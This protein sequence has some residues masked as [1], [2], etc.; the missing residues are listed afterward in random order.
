MEARNGRITTLDMK[1]DLLALEVAVKSFKG[2]TVVDADR[3]I[4][5]I[6]TG[7]KSLVYGNIIGEKSLELAKKILRT[8]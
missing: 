4:K 7:D 8:H 3:V 2:N 1:A 6:V 5:R